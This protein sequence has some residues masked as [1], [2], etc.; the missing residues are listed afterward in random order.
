MCLIYACILS[1]YLCVFSV[2]VLCVVSL[3]CV[4]TLCLFLDFVSLWFVWVSRVCGLY[5]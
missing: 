2:F 1:V 3:L 5:V 4:C